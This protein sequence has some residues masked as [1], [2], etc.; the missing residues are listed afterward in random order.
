AHREPEATPDEAES[1]APAPAVDEAQAGSRPAESTF[2]EVWRPAAR[3]EGR[4]RRLRRQQRPQL[5]EVAASESSAA[6]VVPPAEGATASA[7]P[8]GG[9]PARGPRRPRDEHGDRPNR[10]KRQ[11]RRERQQRMERQDERAQRKERNA[12]R[13]PSGH[14]VIAVSRLIV[15]NGSSITQSLSAALPAAATNRTRIRRLPSSLR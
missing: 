5:S 8:D 2:V 10:E 4:P 6:P 7:S 13:A 15:P 3:F 14:A 11:D 12:P 9:Q 1:A